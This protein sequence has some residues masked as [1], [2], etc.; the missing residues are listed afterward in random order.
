MTATI[1]SLHRNTDPYGLEGGEPGQRGR[2]TVIRADGTVDDPEGQRR[3]RDAG[4]RRLRQI[5][6]P[7]GGGFGLAAE[8]AEA[9]E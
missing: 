3:D 7:G 6:T 8:R 5:E 2:N 4:G 9:A 1:L